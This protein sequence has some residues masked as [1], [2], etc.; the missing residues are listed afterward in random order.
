MFVSVH[1]GSFLKAVCAKSASTDGTFVTHTQENEQLRVCAVQRELDNCYR[2]LSQ[3][4]AELQERIQWLGEQAVAYRRGKNMAA[5]KKKMLERA[6]VQA[7]LTN[8]QNSMG[9]VEMHR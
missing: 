8:V 7:Q 6:R 1:G 5:A 9:T 4:E 3:R 2:K